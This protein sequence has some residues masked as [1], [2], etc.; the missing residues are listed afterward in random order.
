MGNLLFFP[1]NPKAL[2][3]DTETTD[4]IHNRTIKDK[5][6]PKIIE[7][8]GCVVDLLSETSPEA[9][10]D[11]ILNP[12]E[13]IKPITT[14]VTGL[15]DEDVK[16]KSTFYDV[17][18]QIRDFLQSAPMVIAHNASFDKEVVD[19]EMERAGLSVNWPEVVCTVESTTHIKGTR[20]TLGDLHEHVLGWRF[21]NAHRARNDVEAL[22]RIARKLRSE[23][24][25]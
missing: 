13:P 25:I 4:L 24:M 19:V 6:R 8:Y 18:E 20:L 11:L 15:T 5:H 21:Q 22:V 14:K 16:D 2:V 9:E 7:F 10:L 3:F 17:A 1:S 12:Q 23:G